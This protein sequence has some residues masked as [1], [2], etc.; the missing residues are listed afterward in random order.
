MPCSDSSWRCSSSVSSITTSKISPWTSY[1][2]ATSDSSQTFAKGECD[3][4]RLYRRPGCCGRFLGRRRDARKRSH[5]GSETSSQEWSRRS[6]NS[7]PQDRNR[8]VVI[9][10][11]YWGR[12]PGEKLAAA[13]GSRAVGC[14]TCRH[15]GELG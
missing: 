2:A 6:R 10:L 11:H 1:S 8:P 3:E 7:S 9:F 15:A 13:F 14:R 5:R 12:G 4:K